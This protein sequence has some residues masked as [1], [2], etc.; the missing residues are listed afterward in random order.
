MVLVEIE[1]ENITEVFVGFG[2]RG[3]RAEAVAS[4]AADQARRY[5][6]A[7]VPIGRCLANQLLVP[8]ALGSGGEF[9]TMPLTKHTIT[10]VAVI[11]QFLAVPID[12]DE[13]DDRKV[14]IQLRP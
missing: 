11:K 12:V 8:M 9:T 4:R 13:V 6:A 2:E 14:R 3:V 7:D 10:N 5:L 1:S